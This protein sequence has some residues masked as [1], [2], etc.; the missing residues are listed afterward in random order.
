MKILSTAG[1]DDIA[2]VYVAETGGNN[3][4]EFVESVQPPIP[5][6]DKWVLIVSTLY[7]CPVE[8]SMCDAGGDYRGK[9]SYDDIVSQIDYL[10]TKRYPDRR[11]PVNK[12]KIQFARMG[13]P[14]LNPEVIKV[15]QNLPEIY[16]A[17]GLIPCIS[18]VAPLGCDRFFDN[19]LGIKKD[20][21]PE[22][23]QL[24]FSIH[25]TDT[26][27][28]DQI[29]PIKKWDFPQ[30][31]AYSKRF[32]DEGGKKITLNFALAQDI[33]VD[34]DTILTFFPPEYFFIKITPINPTNTAIKQKMDLKF[35]QKKA[36]RFVQ[37]L[38]KYEYTTM[39][40]IGE[41][42]EN[43]IGSN[44]GMYASRINKSNIPSV[45]SYSYTLKTIF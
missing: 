1:R 29:I 14:A 40:S 2:T 6:K 7:G 30:I 22:S 27:I 11:V 8:C 10:V 15:L 21:Y 19:L 43:K 38:R 39:I 3:I 44:C 17:P 9:I 26:E 36:E 24:Q 45:V 16:S 34:I 13:E 5:R 12:F 18:T 32:Y 42:E 28:R 37:K 35:P 41:L 4:I 31:S 23:F 33:P 25:S 20:L